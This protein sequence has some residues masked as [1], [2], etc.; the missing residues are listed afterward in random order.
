[1]SPTLEEI[2]ASGGNVARIHG[3]ELVCTA[4]PAS[5]FIIDGFRDQVLGTEDGRSLLFR[6]I[7]LGV[8]LPTKDSKGGQ[9]LNFATDNT[10]GE[11]T[12]YLELSKAANAKVTAIFRTW[13]SSNKLAPAEKPYRM[14][15]LGGELEGLI[16]NLQC[17][18]HNIVMTAYPRRYMTADFAPGLR[19]II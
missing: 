3:L 6:A 7:N 5:I 9:T 13:L 4:W 18:Y 1:M 17:G 12:K 16:A 2:N 11:V 19:Y 8:S 15:V 14:T 10:T